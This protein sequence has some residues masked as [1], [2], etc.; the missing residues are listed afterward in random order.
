MIKI[1]FSAVFPLLLSGAFKMRKKLLFYGMKKILILGGTMFVGRTLT[2]RLANSGLYSVTLFNRGKS[3]TEVFENVQQLHGDR[4][5]ADIQKIYGQDWDCIIDFSG[6]YPN[7][8]AEL[9]NGISGRVGRYIFISTISVYDLGKYQHKVIDETFETLPCSPAQKTSR[10]PDAY[11]EKKAEMD[12][13]LLQHT[14]L[15]KIIFRPSFIYGKYDYT[16]RFYYWLYRVEKC[17]QFLLPD[18][19]QP[20]K[21]CLTNADDLTEALVQAVEIKAHQQIYNAISTPLTSIREL[22]NTAARAYHK[23]PGIISA[24][25]AMLQEPGVHATQFPL[26]TPMDVRVSDA[27]FKKDFPFQRADMA[28]TLLEMRDYNMAT[29][30]N[31]PAVGLDVEKEQEIIARGL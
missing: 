5:T 3:N 16:Q 14:E 18:D 6:Y 24:S 22:V 11:G 13:I 10:L 29:G 9:L 21:V 15:D 2:Q 19:G 25:A 20:K 12:R 17:A 28:N 1:I 8:F 4:E 30:F 27:L 23:N 31:K 7:S 26:L